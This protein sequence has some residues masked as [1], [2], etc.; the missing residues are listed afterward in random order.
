[1]LV[2]RVMWRKVL[3]LRPEYWPV[4]RAAERLAVLLPAVQVRHEAAADAKYARLSDEGK[5]ASDARLVPEPC[6]EH[7]VCRLAVCFLRHAELVRLVESELELAAHWHDQGHDRRPNHSDGLETVLRGHYREVA[8][9]VSVGILRGE[10][11]QKFFEFAGVSDETALRAAHDVACVPLWAL[12][13][14]AATFVGEG[15]KESFQR[16]LYGIYDQFFAARGELWRRF[17]PF[18]AV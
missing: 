7:V 11:C 16:S 14:F 6:P 10:E 13:K 15:A 5:S 4:E 3:G 1:M 12:P 9:E 2:T 18:R 17:P 8:G